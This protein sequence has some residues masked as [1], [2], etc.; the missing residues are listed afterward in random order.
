[1]ARVTCLHSPHAGHRGGCSQVSKASQYHAGVEISQSQGPSGSCDQKSH[2]HLE[3]GAGPDS[4]AF[5]AW[6]ALRFPA[7]MCTPPY[8]RG[9]CGQNNHDTC[10]DCSGQAWTW[11][12]AGLGT[13][14]SNATGS[15]TLR[16]DKTV[17]ERVSTCITLDREECR[18]MGN[19]LRINK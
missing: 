10:R 17:A 19:F 15:S 3:R 4:N 16:A 1:M 18:V 8:I 5:T 9:L 13:K 12:G 11:G 2:R 7:S 14:L 6:P